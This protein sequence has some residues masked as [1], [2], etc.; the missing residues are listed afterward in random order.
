MLG[1]LREGQSH[2]VRKWGVSRDMVGDKVREEARTRA[3]DGVRNGIG[4]CW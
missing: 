2:T 3:G 4:F 1:L